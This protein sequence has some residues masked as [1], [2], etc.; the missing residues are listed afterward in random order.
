[1]ELTIQQTDL[2]FAAGKALGSVSAKSPMPLL[3]CLLLEADKG[4]LRVTGTDLEITTAV[5]VPCEVESPGR[6]AV[7]GRHFHEVVRKIARGPLTLSQ[8]GE[9]CEVRYGNGKGWSRF[10]TRA[11]AV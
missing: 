9:Q 7:P 11:S 6:V 1:M 4:A 2:A 3:S 5:T 8:N 10:P